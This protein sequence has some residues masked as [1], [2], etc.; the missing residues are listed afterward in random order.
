MRIRL[1]EGFNLLFASCV[2]RCQPSGLA[3]GHVS[4]SGVQSVGCQL[5]LRY[6]S[7][8]EMKATFFDVL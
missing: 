2:S 4:R 5:R 3:N 7:A 1:G 8:F 6:F